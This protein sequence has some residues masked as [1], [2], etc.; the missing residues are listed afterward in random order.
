MGSMDPISD[1][2]QKQV[3]GNTEKQAG[4]PAIPRQPG[5][6]SLE[7][8]LSLA[9]A[10]MARLRGPGGCPWDRDQTFDSIRRYT[11]EEAYEVFD[12]IDR[13]DWDD[14][15]EEL[16]DLF[17][18]VLFYAQ[19]AREAGF[20]RLEDVIAGLN[21][22]LIR[23]HPHVFAGRTGIETAGQ[24]R[25]SWEEIKKSEREQKCGQVKNPR[26]PSLLDTVLRSMPA[27][28]EAQ[29]LGSKAATVGFD[30]DDAA[31][32]FDKLQEELDE[33]RE[34]MAAG[35]RAEQEAELGDVLF[36]VVNLA[37]KLGVQ[38]EFALR[39]SNAKFRRRFASMEKSR[40]V[41]A[42]LAPNELEALWD[43]AKVAEQAAAPAAERKDS[44]RE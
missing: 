33:L 19:I 27:L 39:S 8:K 23:R 13:K 34:A 35:R 7:Q 17:L 18:Q 22:K 10:I 37:R 42:G 25:A 9:A 16:G 21:D 4:Q 28:A 41:L 29:K 5:P 3:S 11:L 26:E 20:F 24:V 2:T 36:T 1:R 43:Q 31:P 30:W 12:A 40:S 14:L 15:K 38:A 44:A 32:V 6:D